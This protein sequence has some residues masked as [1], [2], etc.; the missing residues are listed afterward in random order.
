ML[1]LPAFC[2]CL[3]PWGSCVVGFVMSVTFAV[4]LS[5][6]KIQAIYHDN[7]AGSSWTDKP[8][9]LPATRRPVLWSQGIFHSI[10]SHELSSCL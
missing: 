9:S 1:R 10:R 2:G 8:R 6:I 5:G 7:K 3:A 4:D